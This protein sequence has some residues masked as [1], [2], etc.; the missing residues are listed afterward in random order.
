[1]SRLT[2]I[3]GS[4]VGK[5]ILMAS[6]GIVLFGFVLVHM[7][8]NLKL[9]QGAEKLNGYAEWLRDVGSP[10]LPHEAALWIFRVALLAAVGV[11]IWAAWQL[12]RLNHRARPVRYAKKKAVAATYAA[13]TMRVSGVIIVSFVIYHLFHL[14]W[15]STHPD[16]AAHKPYENVVSAFQVPWAAGA[17]IVANLL[18][19]MHLYHGLWSLFQTLGLNDGGVTR[20]LRGFAFTFALVVTAGNLSFPISVML[21]LVE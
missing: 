19:G 11:H 17:Y 14:T 15:G 1:M 3:L 20:L 13:R 8:G 12:T 21:K 9:Y 4:A 5:K 10:A 18:L 2:T 7:L 16:F 6:S